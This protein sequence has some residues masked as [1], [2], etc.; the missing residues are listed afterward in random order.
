MLTLIPSI[1]VQN[2]LQSA[3]ISVAA[4]TYKYLTQDVKD[5]SEVGISEC[6]DDSPLKISQET[7][8][9]S[10]VGL[11]TARA[12]EPVPIF[13]KAESEK[14]ISNL[15][16]ASIVLGRD[17]S[18]SKASG[19]GGAGHSQCGS[20]DIVAGRMSAVGPRSDVYADPSF[21]ADAA[22]IYVSQKADID[23]YLNLTTGCVGK[24]KSRSAIG[25]KADS[26][27]IASRQGIKLVTGA[28]ETNS[29]GGLLMA[30]K[31]IDLIAGNNDEDLQPIPK[32]DNLVEAI[33]ELKDNLSDLNGVVMT[34]LTNQ[35]IFNAGV[36]LHTHQLT[37]RLPSVELQ[38]IGAYTASQLI[39]KVPSV[40]LNKANM[41]MFELN[42]L[43]PF[44]QKWICG[45]NRTN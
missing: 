19:Y 12:T 31:G 26:V 9:P 10:V 18:G 27:R 16:N 23:E 15:N 32:G 21:K 11:N 29:F 2:K 35:M 45:Y 22:R 13:N 4:R 38:P 36:Q 33:R 24:S 1:I 39:S 40:W 30:T 7:F 44:S 34:F 42:Y 43:Y 28:D 3:F 8:D 37:A 5:I 41:L 6:I 25:I 14:V 17:R 20:I